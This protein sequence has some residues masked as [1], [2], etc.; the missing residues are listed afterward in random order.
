MALR[1]SSS[2]GVTI[3]LANSEDIGEMTLETE[4][5]VAKNILLFADG[6]GGAF[7]APYTAQRN[8]GSPGSVA[9]AAPIVTISC[10][11]PGAGNPAAVAHHA[12]GFSLKE[13]AAVQWLRALSVSPP[14]SRA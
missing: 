8:T 12:A 6:F 13:E 14:S 4:Q 7:F 10:R 2:D 1:S 9:P 5:T 11:A 3:L